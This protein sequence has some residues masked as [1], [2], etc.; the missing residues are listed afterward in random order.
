MRRSA[1]RRFPRFL[2]R[3]AR[4]SFSRS[5]LSRDCTEIA[6]E[7]C[8]PLSP[9]RLHADLRTRVYARTY[10]RI[11][12]RG[13]VRRA[14]SRRPAERWNRGYFCRHQSLVAGLKPHG[15][16]ERERERERGECSHPGREETPI[17]CA[18][19]IQWRGLC[20]FSGIA[21][22]AILPLVASRLL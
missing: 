22:H 17:S 13:H 8:S 11:R 21:V 19:M 4:L 20:S 18:D 6:R 9:R 14:G 15:A 2:A 12:T 10:T 5:L 3:R 7:I 1:A 16:S